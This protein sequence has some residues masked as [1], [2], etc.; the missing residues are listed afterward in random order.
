MKVNEKKVAIVTGSSS[1]IGLET[2]LILARNGYSTYASMR[3]MEKS[4]TIIDLAKKERLPLQVIHL[5]VN[6]DVIIKNAIS[7]IVEDGKRIDILVNNAGYGLFGALEDLSIEEIKAQFETNFFGVVRVT[8]AVLPTMRNQKGGG[9]IVNISSVGG[10]VSAPILSAYNSTKFAL[11]GL[12]ES[13]SHELGPCG[14]RV[15]IIE[16]G[17]IKTNIMNSSISAKKASGQNSPYYST[18]QRIEKY[19]KSMMDNPES[20]TPDEVAKVILHAVTSENPQ[21]RFTV[22]NDASAIM[23]AKREL[24][25]SEFLKLMKQQLMPESR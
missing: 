20:S 12:S 16:P 14:I 17:F 18:T 5:D 25:E 7:R 13:I 1:G 9:T 4:K 2:A 23:Q 15:I 24:S 6:D 22:G 21:L 3:N 10:Q 8:Q 19:F 11:E